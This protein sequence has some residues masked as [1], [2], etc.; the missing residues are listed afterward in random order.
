MAEAQF[1]LIDDNTLIQIDPTIIYQQYA[2]LRNQFLQALVFVEPQFDFGGEV[3]VQL[4]QVL[5]ENR[6]YRDEYLKNHAVVQQTSQQFALLVQKIKQIQKS[7]ETKKNEIIDDQ[8]NLENQLEKLIQESLVGREN[9]KK[10]YQNNEDE[11]DNLLRDSLGELIDEITNNER[12][13]EMLEN[14]KK[15]IQSDNAETDN[16]EEMKQLMEKNNN[17]LKED[18]EEK[19]KAYGNLEGKEKEV[20]NALEESKEM[21]EDKQAFVEKLQKQNEE[22]DRQLEELRK[23]IE[24]KRQK[25][26]KEK[27]EKEIEKINEEV[28]QH[29]AKPKNQIARIEE[30]FVF[31]VFIIINYIFVN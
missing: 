4:Q 31:Y 20:A 2:L 15:Q 6:L 5:N 8:K 10:T 21:L 12:D 28:E 26:E 9:V 7:Y 23:K 25:E 18:F 13:I 1:Q 29:L 17:Q 30:K 14:Q 22:M 11:F 27:E 19:T 24:E 16:I 3:A